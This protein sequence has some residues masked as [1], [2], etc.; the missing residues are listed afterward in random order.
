MRMRLLE[1]PRASSG[2]SDFS[3]KAARACDS[4]M[5]NNEAQLDPIRHHSQRAAVSQAIDTRLILLQRC[6]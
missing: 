6:R 5:D 2:F 1:S 4:E 3:R